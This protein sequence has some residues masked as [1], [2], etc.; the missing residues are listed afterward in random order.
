L[1]AILVLVVA[2]AVILAVGLFFMTGTQVQ[3]SGGGSF[4]VTLTPNN[5]NT[6]SQP[7]IPIGNDS[8]TVIKVAVIGTPTENVIMTL[9]SG[10]AERRNISYP[11]TLDPTFVTL[12][13]LKEY[14]I[15]IL[16]GDPYFDM[17]AREAVN[18]YVRD[19][20]SLI[21]VGDAGSKHP[22]YSNVAG[23][24][25]PSGDGIPVPAQMVGELY[26]YIDYANGSDLRI[27]RSAHPIIK[28]IS[29]VGS[30][31]S[32]TS[33]VVKV[34]SKG[35]TLVAIDT[36]EGTLPAIIE[37]SAGLGKVIYFAYDPGQTPEILLATVKYL[38][39]V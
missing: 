15:V 30:G 8:K 23:W 18:G 11:V 22:S 6:S 1:L 35:D 17:N 26:G 9:S 37:G 31:L 2:A 39:G 12:D 16:Q 28:G 3:V 7:G 10:E 24:S 32:E 38:T 13:I 36:D 4:N 20:G 14:D 21:I 5:Q 34:I 29:L 33:Q 25:W 19:G 27:L